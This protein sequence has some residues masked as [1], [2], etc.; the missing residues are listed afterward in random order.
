MLKNEPTLAIR[1]VD[2]AENGPCKV[3]PTYPP[4]TDPPS[5]NQP[6]ILDG[7]ES[8]IKTVSGVYFPQQRRHHRLRACGRHRRSN[9]KQSRNFKTSAD[10]TFL[11]ITPTPRR[12]LL[13]S[14]F[15]YI[16]YTH[17]D[18]SKI[19]QLIYK[20]FHFWTSA[21]FASLKTQ[22]ISK[23]SSNYLSKFLE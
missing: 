15:H 8:T 23:L 17:D 19:I 7:G 20:D 13:L 22:K 2:T 3:W 21:S 11:Q 16:P 5:K 18:A 9:A 14:N 10:H 12:P 4:R 1:S 6:W